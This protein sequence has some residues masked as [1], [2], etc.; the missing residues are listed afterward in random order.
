MAYKFIAETVTNQYTYGDDVKFDVVEKFYSEVDYVKYCSRLK[1]ETYVKLYGYNKAE[2]NYF[3]QMGTTK[4][5]SVSVYT[6][7]TGKTDAVTPEYS[8]DSWDR[9]F[10]PQENETK[11]VL[12][13]TSITTIYH[14]RVDGT[15]NVDYKT[16]GWYMWLEHYKEGSSGSVI[17][18]EEWN[19][20]SNNIRTALSIPRQTDI[21]T[22]SNFTDDFDKPPTITY[23]VK[24]S[25]NLS[26]LESL[27]VCISL[28][29]TSATIP[30]RDLSPNDVSYTFDFDMNDRMI[31]HVEAQGATTFPVWFMI[32]T[33]RN[34]AGGT[35][36][37]RTE[38]ITKVE[39]I[40]TIVGDNLSLSPT[41]EDVNTTTLE[42]TGDKNTIVKYHSNAMYDLNA[43]SNMGGYITYYSI[44]CG[45]QY[46]TNA[47]GTM[48]AVESGDFI[49]TV[50]DSRGATKTQTISKTFIDYVKLT[51]NMGGTKPD[52][53]GNFNLIVKGNA[54]NGSFGKVT[55]S[56]AVAYR[57]KLADDT[58]FS[59]WF[60][61]GVSKT[62]NTYTA[63][64][65]I[66]GLDYRAKY[67]FQA[68]AIDS[69][70]TV[71]TDETDI[72]ALPVFD[73]S[74]SDFNFN[75]DVRIQGDL[76]L[77][78]AGNYGNTLYFGDGS[79]SYITESTDDDLTIKSTDITLSASN[80]N[81]NGTSS[82]KMN[83]V[84]LPSL[85]WGTW[86]PLLTSSGAVSSYNTRE[87]W[88]LRMGNCVVIGWNINVTCN[89]GY[90]TTTIKIGNAP[91]F[92]T[93]S[94]F[95]GGVAYNMY[96]SGGFAFQ[97]WAINQSDGG[98]TPRL[99]PCNNTTA[100]NLN[101]SSSGFYTQGGGDMTL[102]GTICYMT[103][104]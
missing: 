54:F 93:V 86:T 47:S 96:V 70:S 75:C 55:N 61:M 11:E 72:T 9:T 35:E 77:K 52:T 27:Q 80:I 36:Y 63:T 1:V 83:G 43:Y 92:P 12:W 51:C 74:E 79:Y 4:T 90:H 14:S 21:L 101:I 10:F 42:L 56:L 25:H 45:G 66:T 81:L 23:S 49:F 100:G 5:A 59:E 69:L 58:T 19:N 62:D 67:V 22:A 64:A 73:W 53:N 98:I 103:D 85:Q 46:A 71:Y 15:E 30:Y 104:D 18:D 50:K 29:G 57:Y 3:L 33:V 37:D 40:F 16:S 76:R 20:Q 99:Q 8:I 24:P 87:G 88:Y 2:I 32:K 102:S 89:S 34:V 7:S 39:R 17:V 48:Y 97:G 68:R 65:Q 60:E 6:L 38:I 84:E 44:K 78:G 91:F 31:L 82:I 95:G 13:R 26:V 28:N 94:A 41:V